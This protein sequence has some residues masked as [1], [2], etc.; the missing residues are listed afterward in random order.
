MGS[1]ILSLVGA[2]LSSQTLV[3]FRNQMGFQ[4]LS[5]KVAE[6]GGAETYRSYKYQV[7]FQILL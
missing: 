6:V 5:N 3:V 1:G 4:A 2:S 7:R